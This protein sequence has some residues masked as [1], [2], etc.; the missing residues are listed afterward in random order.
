MLASCLK[1]RPSDS[2]FCKKNKPIGPPPRSLSYNSCSNTGRTVKFADF[3]GERLEYVK[4][5]TPNSSFED[6]A[7]LGGNSDHERRKTF[8]LNQNI[9]LHENCSDRKEPGLICTFTPLKN[10]KAKDSSVKFLSRYLPQ[11]LFRADF[12][13][14]FENRNVCLENVFVSSGSPNV[15]IGVIRV[16]NLAYKKDIFVRYTLN[17]WKDHK[18]LKAEFAYQCS[19]GK[20]DKFLFRLKIHRVPS[21]ESRGVLEF[22]ICCKM[23]SIVFWDNNYGSNYRADYF[24]QL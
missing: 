17:R 14:R 20:A 24:T 1:R 5:I 18:D 23:S 15:L 13:Q 10:S 2:T 22:A 6:F 4:T 9:E 11:P 12:Y 16:K 8:D 3:F 7:S 21:Q 19:D